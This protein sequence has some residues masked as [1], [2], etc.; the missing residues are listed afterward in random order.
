MTRAQDR[1]LTRA[2]PVPRWKGPGDPDLALVQLA[3]TT[4]SARNARTAAAE[5]YA[6]AREELVRVAP[7]KPATELGPGDLVNTG[8]L[9]RQR[10]TEVLSIGVDEATGDVNLRVADGTLLRLPAERAVLVLMV[11]NGD[12]DAARQDATVAAGGLAAAAEELARWDRQL[13]LLNESASGSSKVAAPGSGSTSVVNA[14]NRRV[15]SPV[16]SAFRRR[17]PPSA[18]CGTLPPPPPRPIATAG[19]SR[20]PTAHWVDSPNE[21]DH[22]RDMAHALRAIDVIG[23]AGTEA[24]RSGEPLGNDLLDDRRDARSPLFAIDCRLRDDK[25]SGFIEGH[26]TG[27]VLLHELDLVAADGEFG[28]VCRPKNGVVSGE[29]LGHEHSMQAV[30]FELSRTQHGSSGASGERQ[31]QICSRGMP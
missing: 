22:R 30:G 14:L 4:E 23:H 9:H 16:L 1:N 29:R 18:S 19:A 15:T 28:A 5:R 8:N 31:D 26:K 27:A 17:T 13:D 3:H 10:W 11:G 24:D 12:V 25:A 2:Q 6:R 21:C 7:E 20:E